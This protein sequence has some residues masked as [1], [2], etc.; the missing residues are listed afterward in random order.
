MD[1]RLLISLLLAGCTGAPA[2]PP[3]RVIVVLVDT[4]RADHLGLYGYAR[5]T[6]PALDRWA[7]GATVFTAARSPAPWTLPSGR[8]LLGADAIERFDPGD[9]VATRL[10]AAG[11][12]TVALVANPN[13]SADVGFGGGWDV[14]SLQDGAPA[15]VQVAAALAALASAPADT[16]VF[17]LLHLMDPHLPYAESPSLRNRWAGEAPSARLADGFTEAALRGSALHHPLTDA[18]T[19]HLIDRYDQNVRAVDDAFATLLGAL[20]PTDTVIF[21]ADH[22][23]ALGEH[24]L[25]GHGVGLTEDQVRV[26]LVVSGPG[27]GAARRPD[28][29]SLDDV[30][31]TVLTVAGLTPSGTGRSLGAEP[32]AGPQRLSH[33][34]YGPARFGVVDGTRKWVS[35]GDVV[36][37]YDLLADPPE[38]AP[39]RGPFEGAER[40]AWT[41]AGGAPLAGVWIARLAPEREGASQHAETDVRQVDLTHPGGVSRAWSPP[42][43]LR[44]SAP[45][46]VEIEDGVRLTVDRPGVMPR[47]VFF[48]APTDPPPLVHVTKAGEVRSI[49]VARG[50]APP[51]SAH[52]PV[53]LPAALEVLGYVEP[54]SDE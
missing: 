15:R 43:P 16:P 34:R 27:W 5:D 33:T 13:L 10:D 12:H 4:L 35:T 28:A 31:A 42:A 6:S 53:L 20:R 11:W 37:H 45:L 19:Q 46:E 8:A 24:G 25:V 21:T 3:P 36:Q 7:A 30:G 51:P 14:S 41:R 50:M 54:G 48:E 1:R 22:G 23:E 9:T 29:V 2:P 47:T 39:R 40:L 52:L 18:E 49:P 32:V 26:P 44:R 38:L 17:L